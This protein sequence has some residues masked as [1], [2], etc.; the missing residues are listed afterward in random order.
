M[1]WNANDFCTTF[2]GIILIYSDGP[3]RFT[4]IDYKN[5][6]I[7]IVCY[8]LHGNVLR[9]FIKGYTMICVLFS[10]N[11][12]MEHKDIYFT[13]KPEFIMNRATFTR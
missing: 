6:E 3:Y 9:K 4:N 11:V 8:F 1:I 7:K 2:V 10:K 12:L 13:T 5:V